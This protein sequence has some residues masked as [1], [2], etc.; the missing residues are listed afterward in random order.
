MSDNPGGGR[1]PL[2][3]Q[4]NDVRK[5]HSWMRTVFMTI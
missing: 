1:P 4:K 3:R 2:S 5:Y